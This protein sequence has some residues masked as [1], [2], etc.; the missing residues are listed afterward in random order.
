MTTIFVGSDSDQSSDWMSLPEP[1]APAD[2]QRPIAGRFR[3]LRCTDEAVKGDL[4]A[5]LSALSVRLV[6]H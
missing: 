2:S 1:W 4:K 5:R 6:Q 3:M